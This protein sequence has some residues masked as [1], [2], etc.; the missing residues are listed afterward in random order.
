VASPVSALFLNAFHVPP[1]TKPTTAV[2]VVIK[3][4]SQ[5]GYR[6]AELAAY[7]P[8]KGFQRIDRSNMAVSSVNAVRVCQ[9]PPPPHGSAFAGMATVP[10]KTPTTFLSR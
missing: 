1:I 2:T 5:R 10:T 9:F 3:T 6:N 4:S 8:T 7:R